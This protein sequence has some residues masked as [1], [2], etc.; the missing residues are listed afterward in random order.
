MTESTQP[1]GKPAEQA[2][3][4]KETKRPY[5]VNETVHNVGGSEVRQTLVNASSTAA[6][7]RHAARR[8]TAHAARPSE[9]AQLMARGVKLEE[10]G[11]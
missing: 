6:A 2:T 3:K 11:S 8:F 9:V 5:V 1:Q 10:A 4:K 7:C